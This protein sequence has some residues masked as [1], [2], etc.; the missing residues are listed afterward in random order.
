MLKTEH[1]NIQCPECGHAEFKQPENAKDDD[2]VRC[3]GCEFEIMLSDLKEI[4]LEQAKEIVIPEIKAEMT[5]K[6]KSMFKGRLK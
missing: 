1:I 4:G 6:F 2:F 5:K 3:V